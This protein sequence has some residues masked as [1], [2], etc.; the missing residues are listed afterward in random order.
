VTLVC[1]RC[2]VPA[3][4]G[5]IEHDMHPSAWM[6]VPADRTV[7]IACWVLDHEECTSPIFCKCP[8]HRERLDEEPSITA[9]PSNR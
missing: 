5:R 1:A 4:C 7:S 6:T 3:P 2:H 9:S 8:C